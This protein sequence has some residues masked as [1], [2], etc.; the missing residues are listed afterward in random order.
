MKRTHLWQ[1]GGFVVLFCLLGP[2]LDLLLSDKLG[3][4]FKFFASYRTNGIQCVHDVP[5]I[6]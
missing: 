1:R 4:N 5:N 3:N 6:K 2:S